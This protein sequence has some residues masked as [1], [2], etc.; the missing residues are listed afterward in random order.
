MSIEDVEKIMDETQDAVQYQ[1]VRFHLPSTLFCRHAICISYILNTLYFMVGID[2]SII[3][4]FSYYPL[5][6]LWLCTGDRRPVV[7]RLDQRG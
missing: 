3:H 6:V 5:P 1:Q 7:R 4:M 2:H